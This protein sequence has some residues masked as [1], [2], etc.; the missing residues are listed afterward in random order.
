MNK[1]GIVSFFLIAILVV[2]VSVTM[3]SA[4]NRIKS[5]RVNINASTVTMEVGN[6]ATLTAIM[7]PANSTDTLTWSVSDETIVT[8]NS[9]G[10]VTA[11]AAGTAT[12]KVRTSSGK[13][14]SCKVTVKESLSKA[15]VEK[16]VTSE[17]LTDESIKKLIL[18]NVISEDIVKQ[19]IRDNTSSEADM[20]NLIRDNTL[21]KA[22]VKNLIQSENKPAEWTDGVEVPMIS[23]Q[24][25]PI[26]IND[27][28]PRLN[29]VSNIKSLKVNKRHMTTNI[30]ENGKSRFL[31][32]RYDVIMT[33][34]TTTIT[35][36]QKNSVY[37]KLVFS[38]PNAPHFSEA[39]DPY[40]VS[41]SGNVLTEIVT[42]YSA[43]DVDSFFLESS[44][45]ASK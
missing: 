3:T 31:P 22:D 34:D 42:F 12:V 26:L 23:Q 21:S 32:Y 2:A 35:E 11:V 7:K 8:V 6:I 5:K 41:F 45:W 13:K 24:H 28:T 17:L 39:N 27:S 10:V 43:Y 1:K 33:A 19:L 29:I 30:I 36:A 18:D 40:S 44:E 20:K 14:A 9:Y 37:V 4:K 15:E 25:F 38:A 16:L